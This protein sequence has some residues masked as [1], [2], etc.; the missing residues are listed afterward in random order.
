M[1]AERQKIAPGIEIS[2][3]VASGTPVLQGTRIPVWAIVRAL[4][5]LGSV[6]A[7]AR[8]YEIRPEQ[9]KQALTYAA[10]LLEEVR[11]GILPQPSKTR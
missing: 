3:D 6:E 9:V 2:P 8:A 5:D 4:A 10:D 1:S 11:I 7:V